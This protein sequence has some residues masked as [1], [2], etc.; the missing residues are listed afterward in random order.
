MRL[1]RFLMLLSLAAWLG[2]L[3]FFPVVA[4][5]AF[6]TL[7]SH[8]AGLLVRG[9]LLRLHCMAFICGTIFLVTSFIYNHLM[10]GR[11]RVFAASDV[12]I[13]AMLVLTSV[14]QFRIIPKMD[15]LRLSAAD[16]SAMPAAAPIRAQFDSLHAWST[17]IEGTILVLGLTVL[18]LTSRRFSESR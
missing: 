9:S 2:A 12:L 3:I 5:T 11:L 18:Y 7:P 15:S 4:Q 13:A 1:A 8:S 17:R 16:I 10:F 14:S 6:A